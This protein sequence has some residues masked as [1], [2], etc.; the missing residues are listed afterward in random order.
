[1]TP[2]RYLSAGKWAGKA[3]EYSK[4]E[5]NRDVS[6]I[7]KSISDNWKT[8]SEE[9]KP[10]SQSVKPVSQKW[11]S[12]ASCKHPKAIGSYKDDVSFS[13]EEDDDVVEWATKF[14]KE[15]S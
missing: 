4:S 11:E 13:I 10:I 12:Q 8:V 14:I 2:E 15:D 1:L 3:S 5:R 7:L 9:L 6:E